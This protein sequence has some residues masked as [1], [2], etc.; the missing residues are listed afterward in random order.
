MIDKSS[1]NLPKSCCF[2]GHHTNFAADVLKRITNNT[3]FMN[4]FYENYRKLCTF[5]IDQKNLYETY[6]YTQ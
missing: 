3:G 2:I 1:Q 6:L 5:I 4:S